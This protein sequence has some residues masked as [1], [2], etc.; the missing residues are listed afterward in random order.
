MAEKVTKPEERRPARKV[1]DP[2]IKAMD[3]LYTAMESLDGSRDAQLRCLL[4]LVNKYG[5]AEMK[6]RFGAEWSTGPSE[7]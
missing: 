7:N 2:E 5:T 4:W 6:G 3:E 1:R